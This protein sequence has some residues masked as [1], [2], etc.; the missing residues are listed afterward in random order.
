ML[1]SSLAVYIKFEPHAV[2]FGSVYCMQV[3]FVYLNNNRVL[4]TSKDTVGGLPQLIL[5]EGW[6]QHGSVADSWLG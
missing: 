1:I 6:S 5:G 2:K 4:S 3:Y